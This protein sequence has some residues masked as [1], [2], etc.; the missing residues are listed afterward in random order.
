MW[1]LV[2][3]EIKKRGLPLPSTARLP[4]TETASSFE[5]RGGSPVVRPDRID[6]D[7]DG[8][9]PSRP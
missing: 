8:Q 9:P 3:E 5:V 2:W 4:D 6:A 1:D 7:E